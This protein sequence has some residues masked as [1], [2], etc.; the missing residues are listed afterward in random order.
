MSG[1]LE[2]VRAFLREHDLRDGPMI[3]AVSGGADS[4][5][6]VRSLAALK[7]EFHLRP[8]VLAH[9]NH[10]LRGRESDG[11]QTFVEEL[12]HNLSAT[13]P[14]AFAWRLHTVNVMQEKPAGEGFESA[15]RAIRYQWLTSLAEQFQAHWVATGH[16]AN[17]QAETVLHRL[18]RGTGV[19]GL[20]GIPPVRKLGS[21]GEVVRPLLLVTRREV[22][23]YLQELNQPFRHDT[24]NTDLQFTRNRIRHEL[25]PLLQRDYNPAIVDT[26][27]H[28]AQQ[29]A[30]LQQEEETRASELLQRAELPRA[31]ALLI[32]KSEILQKA[33]SH[34]VREMFRLIWQREGWPQQAMGFKEWHR[35]AQVA[36]GHSPACDLPG[37]IRARQ[38][39]RV[40]QVGPVMETG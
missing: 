13:D 24:S 27:C 4:V 8:L 31:G 17:D 37:P 36:V 1:L 19:K 22:E 40:V 35:L 6:L 16:N 29:A 26:L 3:V 33:S 25:L 10:Q 39:G 7:D 15:A 28:L 18:L 30:D 14:N 32:F 11:D 23:E 5:A 20:A 34:Q 2:K 12:Y 21:M 9:L 38:R